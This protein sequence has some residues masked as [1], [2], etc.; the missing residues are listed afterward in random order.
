MRPPDPGAGAD[1]AERMRE[2]AA[3]RARTVCPCSAPRFRSAQPICHEP[4]RQAKTSRCRRPPDQLGARGSHS[5]RVGHV[6]APPRAIPATWS[7]G[8]QPGQRVRWRV[9]WRVRQHSPGSGQAPPPPRGV[10]VKRGPHR[11]PL[12]QGTRR[13]LLPGC[14]AQARGLCGGAG[15]GRGGVLSLQPMTHGGP[16]SDASGETASPA[17]PQQSRGEVGRGDQ[18]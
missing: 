1:S 18:T 14:P 16:G 11:R 5:A 6:H 17:G 10:P 7:P 3:P 2:A 4:D 12:P 13:S 8:R 9:R 15:R